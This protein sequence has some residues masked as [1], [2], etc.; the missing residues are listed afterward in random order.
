MRVI[1]WVLFASVVASAVALP[2]SASANGGA[3][4]DFSRTHYLPGDKV[5]GYAS[6]FIP[7]RKRAILDRGPFFAYVLPGR[8]TI[9]EG[10][11]IPDRAIRV[12]VA[13]IE[14]EKG[15]EF[16]LDLAFRVPE[17]PGAY[18]SVMICNDPCTVSGFRESLSGQISVVETRREAA[19]LT[20]QS[21]L[22]SQV[23]GLRRQ[24]RKGERRAEDLEETLAA[25]E[26]AASDARDHVAAVR[27][28][29]TAAD[30]EVAALR[31]RLADASTE[32]DT[33]VAPA[34]RAVIDPWAAVALTA[35]LLVI[36][37][38]ITLRRRARPVG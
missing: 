21:R 24:V 26:A 14:H 4:I 16:D 28:D 25:T 31:A 17:L 5:A 6:L 9:E 13:T 30:A 18:Y 23:F 29:L 35:G 15:T 20:E 34:P 38:A 12:G 22:Q 27:E 10:H 7:V 11:R 33:A 8:T 32:P 3:Y 36:G 19:L 2:R 37:G 1:R